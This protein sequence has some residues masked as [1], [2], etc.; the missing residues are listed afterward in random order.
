MIAQEQIIVSGK[1][2]RIRA[3]TERRLSQLL[4]VQKDIQQFIDKNPDL[5]FDELDRKKV[6]N[7]W[8]RKADIL[9]ECDEELGLDFFESPDFE[10]TWLK[11]SEDFFLTSRI[12]L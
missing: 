11:K 1:T 2:V 6:A 4:E 5:I 7:W 3:Y 8:K 9:W 10:V 12:Y